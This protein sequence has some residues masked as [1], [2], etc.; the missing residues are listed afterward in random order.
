[1][2]KQTF[3]HLIS[4]P[5]RERDL[6]PISSDYRFLPLRALSRS[7]L[8]FPLLRFLFFLLP[9][10]LKLLFLPHLFIYLLSYETFFFFAFLLLQFFRPDLPPLL[11]SLKS[12]L[13]LSLLLSGS[14]PA[15]FFSF[16]LLALFLL[17]Q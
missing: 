5:Y 6:A 15:S 3:I 1:M 8:S 9:V 7:I 10:L 12:F 4:K 14:I 2:R 17:F 13:C 11:P 16:G